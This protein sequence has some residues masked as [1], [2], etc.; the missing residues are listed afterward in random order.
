[1]T[2]NVTF[3]Q[4][5]KCDGSLTKHQAAETVA[6]DAE[7]SVDTVDKFKYLEETNYSDP[8]DVLLYKV[9]KVEEKK[10]RGQGRYIVAHTLLRIVHKC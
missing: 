8:D 7:L 9:T 10:F 3:D 6:K 5:E 4:H 1:M 2:G